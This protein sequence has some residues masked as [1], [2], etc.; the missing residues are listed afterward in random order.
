M[1][2]RWKID[3]TNVVTGVDMAAPSREMSRA[4][5]LKPQKDVGRLAGGSMGGTG[6]GNGGLSPRI[7]AGSDKILLR[8]LDG[9]LSA[10]DPPLEQ[11]LA[12]VRAPNVSRVN[13]IPPGLILEPFP[14]DSSPSLKG[15]GQDRVLA[16]AGRR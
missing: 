6:G 15:T 11:L 3:T 8:L 7:I 1:P 4:M 5:S 13:V 2:C 14:T 16:V 9:A 12:Q 10:L